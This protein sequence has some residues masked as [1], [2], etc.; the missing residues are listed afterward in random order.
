MQQGSGVRVHGPYRHGNRFRIVITS[1]DRPPHRLSF[2][3]HAEACECADGARGEAVG[4]TVKSAVDAY[5]KDMAERGLKFTTRERAEYRLDEVLQLEANGRRSIR[6]LAPRGKTLYDALRERPTRFGRPPAVDS[7]RAALSVAGMFGRYC[8][9]QNWLRKDPFEDV[10][11]VGR[12]KHGKA[13]LRVD[14]TRKLIDLLVAEGD[15]PAAVAVLAVLV[16][17]PR[18]TEVTDRDVRDLDDNGRLLWI[19]D[20]KTETGKRV[21]EVPEVLR[22]PLLALAKDKIGAAP[23]FSKS[24][25][26]GA[27][28][29]TRHWLLHH[30]KRYCRLAGIPVITTHGVRGTHGSIAKRGGATGELV[31]A[32]L[33]HASPAITHA[34]YVRP[35]ATQAAQT[36]S[37]LRVLQGGA[38]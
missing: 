22:A 20:S 26:R 37:V 4:V 35:E 3:T 12:R 10:K 38:K 18:A 33:G 7:H 31:A 30:V 25:K 13:Q 9:E 27:E 32:Q 29:P 8:V 34:A 2:A 21:L 16:L 1:R 17:G 5:V 15:K 28:K 23:L 11:G 19:P 14:E 6:W 36:A 24:R